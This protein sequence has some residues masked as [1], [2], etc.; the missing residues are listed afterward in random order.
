[1]GLEVVA[2]LLDGLPCQQQVEMLPHQGRLQSGGMVE[3]EGSPLVQR[4][5]A[6][7]AVVG[8]VIQHDDA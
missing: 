8:V 6:Q 7:V 4:Q 2:R 3:V 1:M 5:M